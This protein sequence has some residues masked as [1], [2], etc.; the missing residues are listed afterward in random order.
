MQNDRTL[1]ALVRQAKDIDEVCRVL[2]VMANEIRRKIESGIRKIEDARSMA[3][4]VARI[5]ALLQELESVKAD[6]CKA[7]GDLSGKY[8][9]LEGKIKEVRNDLDRMTK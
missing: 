8:T 2:D 3:A 5:R 9:A 6:A 7:G 1:V 4:E